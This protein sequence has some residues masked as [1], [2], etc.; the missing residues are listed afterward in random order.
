MSR[1]IRHYRSYWSKFWCSLYNKVYEDNAQ[2]NV[3]FDVPWSEVTDEMIEKRSKE[4][5][6]GTG[7]WIWHQKWNGRNIPSIKINRN[8]PKIMSIKNEK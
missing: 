8:Q 4:M 6:E 3:M 1:K 2:N 7:G 5:S